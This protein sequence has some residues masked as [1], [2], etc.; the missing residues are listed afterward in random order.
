MAESKPQQIEREWREHQEALDEGETGL[1][2]MMFLMNCEKAGLHPTRGYRVVA[3]E[4]V[5]AW[6]VL[7]KV[8][9]SQNREEQRALEDRWQAR[10]VQMHSR[11]S[12]LVIPTS[13]PVV[14]ALSEKRRLTRG[15]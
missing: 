9:T 4:R 13:K 6:T 14:N 10:S 1:D 2:R 11:Q 12:A 3:G 15:D 8:K 7:P 5:P